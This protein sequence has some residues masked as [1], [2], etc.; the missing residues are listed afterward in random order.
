MHDN[1][2]SAT[3]PLQSFIL[4]L[5]G[6]EVPYFPILSPPQSVTMRSGLVT[7]QMGGSVGEHSTKDNEEILVILEGAGEV[8]AAGYGRRPVKAGQVVFI[9][10]ATVHNVYNTD[11]APLRYVFIVARAV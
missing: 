10:P 5:P 8:E 6:P 7:L 9:P 1:E 4:T 3:A 2:A 11:A